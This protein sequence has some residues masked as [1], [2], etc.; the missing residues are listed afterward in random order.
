LERARTR[1]QAGIGLG[2]PPRKPGGAIA[3]VDEE[4]CLRHRPVYSP[5]SARSGRLE[6]TPG[7]RHDTL[8]LIPLKRLSQKIVTRLTVEWRPIPGT[9][10]QLVARQIRQELADLRQSHPGLDA[11]LDAKRADS[12]FTPSSTHALQDLLAE[13]TGR[14]PSTITFGSEAAHVRSLANEIVVNRSRRYGNGTSHWRIRPHR[15]LTRMCC[16]PLLGH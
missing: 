2:L 3:R 6:L 9:D 7:G 12:P 10:P 16:L 4:G 1:E 8:Y 13:F 14:P 11:E 15:R 5:N